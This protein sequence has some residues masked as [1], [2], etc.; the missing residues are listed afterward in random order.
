L[1]TEPLDEPLLHEEADSD[2]EDDFIDYLARRLCVETSE[3]RARL[4]A[5]LYAFE[6]QRERPRRSG[7]YYPPAE[8]N[9]QQELTRSA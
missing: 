3:A 2:H 8:E 1:A 7:V 6:L 4:S 9:E 5:W